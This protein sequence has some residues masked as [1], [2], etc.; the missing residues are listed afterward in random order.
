MGE[1]QKQLSTLSVPLASR[2]PSGNIPR[3][4]T[5][6]SSRT[7]CVLSE[8]GSSS[9]GQVSLDADS[10]V[11]PH[12]WWML[13]FKV[14]VDASKVNRRCWIRCQCTDPNAPFISSCSVLLVHCLFLP[15]AARASVSVCCMQSPPWREDWWYVLYV[16]PVLMFKPYVWFLSSTFGSQGAASS[17]A[18]RSSPAYLS[19]ISL[20]VWSWHRYTGI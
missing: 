2:T 16:N 4:Q 18:C 5:K 19:F 12:Y 9:W 20:Q 13:C 17:E 10:W 1:V 11:W 3:D 14:W 6:G 15:G 8:N 7:Y